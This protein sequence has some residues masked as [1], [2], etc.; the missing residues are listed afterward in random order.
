MAKDRMRSVNATVKKELSTLF[1]KDVFPTFT[2]CL[3][4]LAEVKTTS[5]LRQCNVYVSIMGNIGDKQKVMRYLESHKDEFFAHL[6]RRLRMKYTPVIHWCFD[7][8][9]EKADRL[10]NILGD[11]DI[12]QEEKDDDS[13]E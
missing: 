12:P 3:I 8:T 5:D 6:G 10:M 13:Q 4:T 7:D 2:N 9:A 11:L 1:V